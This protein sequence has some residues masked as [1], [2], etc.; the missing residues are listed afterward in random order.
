MSGGHFDYV[1]YKLED[2]R[3]F[4]AVSDLNEMVSYLFM[5][6]KP[7]AAIAVLNLILDL[8]NIKLQLEQRIKPMIPLI[9]AVEW[10]ASGD[11]NAGDIDRALQQ[12]KE[13]KQ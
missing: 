11:W 12:L 2:E 1:E 4:S 3:V 5:I 9:H 10:E 8:D 13:H 6:K 7:E